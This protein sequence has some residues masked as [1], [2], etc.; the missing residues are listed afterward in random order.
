MQSILDAAFPGG[1]DGS[2]HFARN[3]QVLLTV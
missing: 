3:L 1:D 2:G